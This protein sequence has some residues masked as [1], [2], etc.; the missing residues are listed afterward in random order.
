MNVRDVMCKDVISV[1]SDDTVQTLISVMESNHVHEVPVIDDKKLI[2]MVRS[3]QLTQKSVAEPEK[4]KVR[5][6]LTTPPTVLD[7]EQDLDYVAKLILGTGYR[8]LPVVE[9][10]KVIGIVSLHDIVA[11]ISKSKA[12]RQTRAS[13]LISD[14]IT[15]TDSTDIG[16]ARVLMREHNISR[17]PVV[18]D[19]GQLK[20]VVTTFDMLK[21]I[22]PKERMNWYSMA[23]EMDRVMQIPVS[24]IMNDRP[25]TAGMDSSLSDI[26]ILMNKY[27]TSGVIITIDGYPKGIIVPKDLVEFYV[28]GLKKSG[29]YY[30]IIGLTDEDAFVTETVD[31]MIK[32]T[33]QKI[34][35]SYNILN[36]FLHVKKHNLGIKERT[37]Y[38]VRIRLLTDKK[39]FIEKAWAWDL[40]I[41]VDHAL[42]QLERAMFKNKEIVRDRSRKNAQKLKSSI[43]E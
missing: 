38:S 11:E 9:K 30:Q 33:V 3:K 23:A 32:E 26:A 21:A 10:K 1:S 14:L 41:A 20:G 16:K 31:R 15:I 8:A 27:D 29:V 7:P 39:M 28:S 18:D 35:S 4:T 6:M 43:R 40:R 17:L 25:V 13:A 5:S 24:T 42:D 34:I 37:K 22:K 12:F 19:K 36:L 2:G